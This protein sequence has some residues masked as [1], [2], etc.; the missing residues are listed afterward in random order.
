M[1]AVR[2]QGRQDGGGTEDVAAKMAAIRGSKADRMTAVRGKSTASAMPVAFFW[3]GRRCMI[4]RVA[5]AVLINTFVWR[6][7]CNE[8]MKSNE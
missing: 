2:E 3:N 5:Q 1:A 7:I 4:Q 6:F 8:W